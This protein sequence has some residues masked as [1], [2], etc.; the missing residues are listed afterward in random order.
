MGIIIDNGDQHLYVQS[1]GTGAQVGRTVVVQYDEAQAWYF[2]LTDLERRALIQALTFP[3]D[4]PG[5]VCFIGDHVP[6]CEHAPLLMEAAIELKDQ[7]GADPALIARLLDEA[8]DPPLAGPPADEEA[9]SDPMDDPV[10]HGE[11]AF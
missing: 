1:H 11:P 4:L 10:G 3:T 9:W 7:G 6:G 2:E 8:S 5:P